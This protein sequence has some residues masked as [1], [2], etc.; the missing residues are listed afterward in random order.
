MTRDLTQHPAFREATEGA[1]GDAAVRRRFGGDLIHGSEAV[2]A[3]L[4]AHRRATIEAILTAAL[5]F[6]EAAFREQFAGELA[7]E[8]KVW[9]RNKALWMPDDIIAFLRRADA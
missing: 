7:K 1:L 2:T 3:N 4:Q 5:P 6:L 9:R 8:A